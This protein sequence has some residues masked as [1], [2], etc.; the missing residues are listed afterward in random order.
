MEMEEVLSH[1]LQIWMHQVPEIFKITNGVE[2]EEQEEPKKTKKARPRVTKAK[3]KKWL[4]Q[5][6]NLSQLHPQPSQR[7]EK[8]TTWRPT[9]QIH[10]LHPKWS[11]LCQ[12]FQPAQMKTCKWKTCL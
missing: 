5:I 9:R 1:L 11:P 10:F 3:G 12:H 6:I 2:D 4:K 7:L 8:M